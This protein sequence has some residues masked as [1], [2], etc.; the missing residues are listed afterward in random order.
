LKHSFIQFPKV[1]YIHFLVIWGIW[2]F[3]SNLLF[4]N[5]NRMDPMIVT[6]I[7][8]SFKDY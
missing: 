8:L 1:R 3:R 2:K 6:K 5:W 4:E 7:I